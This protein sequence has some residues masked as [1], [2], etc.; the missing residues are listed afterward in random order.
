MLMENGSLPEIKRAGTFGKKELNL[1]ANSLDRE[2]QKKIKA[3]N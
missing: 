2:L 3:Y 1:F